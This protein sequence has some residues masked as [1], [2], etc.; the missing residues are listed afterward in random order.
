MASSVIGA[1]RVNLGLDS[2]QFQTGTKE[3]SSAMDKL[4]S[5]FNLGGAAIAA[6][7]VAAATAVAA[8]ALKSATA[9]DATAKSARRLGESIEGFRAME[10]AAGEAGVD[11]SALTDGVQTMNRELAKGGKGSASAL[12]QLGIDAESFKKQRPSEQLATLAD[13]IQ[14]TGASSGEA[15]ALLQNLG[16]RN[17][18][19]ILA[20][21]SGGAIFRD[22]AKDIAD[23]GLAMSDV[24]AGA[25]ETAN[26]RIGRLALIGKYLGDQLAISVVPALGSLALAFTDSLREGGLLRAVL[27]TIVSAV[28]AV[29]EITSA[30][31]NIITSLA[32]AIGGLVVWVW[33]ATDGFFG[34]GAAITGIWDALTSVITWAYDLITG[35]SDLITATGSFGNAMSLLGDVAVEVWA[36]MGDGANVLFLR[37]NEVSQ[38]IKGAFLGAL[39]TMQAGWAQFLRSI[40]GGIGNIPGM[41]GLADTLGTAAIDAQSGVYGLEGGAADANEFAAN[42]ASQANALSSAMTKPLAS[43]Q[44]LKDAVASTKTEIE[45]TPPPVNELGEA[46]DGAGSKGASAAKKVKDS[47]TE[48]QKAANTG[49]DAI[50][51]MFSGLLD[52]SKS[53]RESLADLIMDIAKMQLMNGFK[54][55]FGADGAFSGVG[56]WLGGLLGKNAAGTEHWRGGLTTVNERGGEIMDLP[57]GTRIIPHDVSNAMMASSGSSSGTSISIDAR[58]AQQGVA[59]QIA[60]QMQRALPDIVNATR[61]SIGKRQSR[62]Y[63]V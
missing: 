56:S 40:A 32:D 30:S 45:A 51:G 25:I 48:V 43:V 47:L 57:S 60:A 49:A 50:G 31:V 5:K 4:K 2:A 26:D 15:S 14:Q 9:I 28:S 1:L 7:A 27:D 13:A 19:M 22:A 10:M 16:V 58:G 59:E 6:A 42:W 17:K 36:R 46:L 62:G 54:S 33:D 29:V 44:A 55:L 12:K 63:S 52:G 37:V 8:F 39:A 20:L 53:L 38:R 3:A 21:V 61:A 18:E 11:V 23:Y 34:L 24:D 41:G 35:F